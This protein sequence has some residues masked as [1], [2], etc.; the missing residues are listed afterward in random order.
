MLSK[1]L[2]ISRFLLVLPVIGSLLLTVSVVVTGLGMLLIEEWNLVQQGEFS[3]RTAKQLTVTVIQTIDMFL[4]GAISYIVAAGIYKL[5]ISQ[6]ELQLLRRIKIEKLEDL[7]K[8]IIGVVAVALAVSFL[9]KAEA[10]ADTLS[11]LQGAAAV[12]LV[13]VA[14]CL[15][16]AVFRSG[17]GMTSFR[18]EAEPLDRPPAG[19]AHDAPPGM[20]PTTLFSTS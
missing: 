12:A 1:L 8:K 4:L 10:A 20:T 2:E 15:I 17:K 5:F 18:R 6:E 13:I 3:A 14:L 19:L 9:G 11:L 16:P 7:E